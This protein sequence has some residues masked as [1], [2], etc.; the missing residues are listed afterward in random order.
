MTNITIMGAPFTSSTNP[1]DG[2]IGQYREQDFELDERASSFFLVQ[3]KVTSICFGSSTVQSRISFFAS[4]TCCCDLAQLEDEGAVDN[5]A[6]D[7][8]LKEL[9]ISIPA[10]ARSA[11]VDTTTAQC[12]TVSNTLSKKEAVCML[13]CL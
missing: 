1:V 3:I 8:V 12:V 11:M 9:G 2:L 13:Q 6:V 5:A 4:W 10:P 7:G